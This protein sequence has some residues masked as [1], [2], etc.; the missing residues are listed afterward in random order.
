VHGSFIGIFGNGDSLDFLAG[1]SANRRLTTL[2]FCEQA[3]KVFTLEQ[4]WTLLSRIIRIRP[5]GLSL[6]RVVG[7]RKRCVVWHVRL[8]AT[9]GPGLGSNRA[10]NRTTPRDAAAQSIIALS[11]VRFRSGL[12]IESERL[13]AAGGAVVFPWEPL[14]FGVSRSQSGC[15]HR[16]SRAACLRRLR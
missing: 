11:R 8:L 4:P 9:R 7:P 14:D 3:K 13:G 16:C 10:K 6:E 5:Y 12:N 15:V 1:A 2:T